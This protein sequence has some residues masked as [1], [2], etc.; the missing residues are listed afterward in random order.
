MLPKINDYAKSFDETEYMIFF[1]LEKK[2]IVQ[3][4]NKTWK[5]NSNTM[6]KGF[7][8]KPVY[9]EKHLKIKMKSYGD[10]INTNFN[11]NEMHK[12]GCYC[13]YL[14]LILINSIFKMRKK[15][16]PLEFLEE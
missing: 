3:K 2:N 10:K 7:D 12:E 6:Q 13:V 8:S 16:Y 9:D 5:K 1:L 4:Y 14:F 15:Y 11:D